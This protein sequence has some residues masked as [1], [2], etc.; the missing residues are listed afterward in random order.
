[1]VMEIRGASDMFLL[2]DFSHFRLHLKIQK[3]CIQDAIY[4]IYNSRYEFTLRPKQTNHIQWF[5]GPRYRYVAV[6]DW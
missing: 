2:V 5:C 4:I 3:L 1:M 6:S